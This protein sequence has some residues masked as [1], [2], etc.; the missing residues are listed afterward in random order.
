MILAALLFCF[1]FPF[2]ITAVVR[3]GFDSSVETRHILV[4]FGISIALLNSLLNPLIYSVR[5][6]QFRVAFIELI[7]RTVNIVKAEEIESRFFGA[8]VRIEA[9]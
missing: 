4:C 7:Y 8:R 6:R 2:G 9:G 5:M 3:H 1:I